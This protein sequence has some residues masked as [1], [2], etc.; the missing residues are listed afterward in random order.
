MSLTYL[1][2]YQD[3][4]AINNLEDNNCPEWELHPDE[5]SA[6]AYKERIVWHHRAQHANTSNSAGPQKH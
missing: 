1:S 3:P 5:A 6:T 2:H 4:S